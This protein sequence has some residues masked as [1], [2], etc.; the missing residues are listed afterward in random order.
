MLW[1]ALK[2]IK[3]GFY[4]DVGAWLPDNDS[5]TKAFYDRGWS[6]I[7]I[8]PE[9]SAFS[10]LFKM[11][12]R[13]INLQLAISDKCGYTDLHIFR[14]TGLSTLIKD[15][16]EIHTK[17]GYP[18][19]I[20]QVPVK[21][22]N[23]IWEE[24]IQPEQ[25]IHFL[26]IDV[27]GMEDAVLRG[28]NWFKHRPWIVVVEATLP[29]TQQETHIKWEHIL[30]TAGYHFAY[31][32]GLNRFYV[33]DEHRELITA[34]KYPPNVFD[35]FK[36]N[37]LDTTEKQLLA[38]RERATR[39][40]N[41]L[42]TVYSSCSWRITHPLRVAFCTMMHIRSRVLRIP[43]IVKDSFERMMS[44]PL[45]SMVHFVVSHPSLKYWA[46]SVVRSSR[47]LDEWM[48]GFVISHGLADIKTSAQV[49]SPETV[50]EELSHF[51]PYARRIYYDLKK[52]IERSRMN[53]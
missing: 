30:L 53:K 39:L 1:R 18:E 19:T 3:V 23:D 40:E 50:S 22:L 29:S 6:G 24:Y 38:E 49:S 14:D 41:E 21:T 51:S 27:E 25:E 16:A 13:D 31:A 20:I 28:N 26:K 48:Y 5:I 36:I 46:V 43:Q 52:A 4:I 37:A 45:K 33:S 11:R 35:G 17:S 42:H 34:F 44:T 15:N 9:P 2:H 8:E 32:D 7:N 12:P 10:I 47:R